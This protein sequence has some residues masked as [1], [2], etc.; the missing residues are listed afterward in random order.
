M[1]SDAHIQEENAKRAGAV[2]EDFQS[3]S[4]QLTR[5]GVDAETLVRKAMDFRVAVPS[6]G[7]GAGG[8]G[9]GLAS[10]RRII[11]RHNGRSHL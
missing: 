2:D 1:L 10:V 5:R 9:I 11:Q 6:W 3:L 4:R 8:T 7:V